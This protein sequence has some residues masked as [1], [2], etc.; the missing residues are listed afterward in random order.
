MPVAVALTAIQTLD[1][2]ATVFVPVEGGYAPRSVTTGRA[3]DAQVEIVAGLKA[4]E[5]Y[6]S[7]GSFVIKAELGKAG[8]EEGEAGEE[9][10]QEAA[11]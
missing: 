7:A 9:S 3:D 5:A 2:A 8:L 1:G 10:E 11:P 4:G 6:V